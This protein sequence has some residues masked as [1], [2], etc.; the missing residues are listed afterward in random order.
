MLRLGK[1][2]EGIGYF[3]VFLMPVLVIFNSTQM[4]VSDAD[5][6]FGSI[7]IIFHFVG[8]FLIRIGSGFKLSAQNVLAL[9]DRGQH[10]STIVFF[11]WMFTV[12]SWM[13]GVSLAQGEITPS[14]LSSLPMILLYAL[15]VFLEVIMY[16]NLAEKVGAMEDSMHQTSAKHQRLLYQ[17]SQSVTRNTKRLFLLALA[18]VLVSVFYFF[19]QSGKLPNG[20]TNQDFFLFGG[21]VSIGIYLILRRQYWNLR[22]FKGL[23]NHYQLHEKP[24][25]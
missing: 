1:V 17:P 16:G 12:F 20:T 8:L 25:P 22:R 9:T 3:G 10:T 13:H 2:M 24:I 11:L 5:R 7:I 21:L 4:Y 14:I 6:L 18:L 19:L 23:R 15:C